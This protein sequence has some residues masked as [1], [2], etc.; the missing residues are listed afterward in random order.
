[1]GVD[2]RRAPAFAARAA[3]D[4]FTAERR[5]LIMEAGRLQRLL[6]VTA[7]PALLSHTPSPISV[8]RTALPASTSTFTTAAAV[9]A[10]S[11]A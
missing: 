1:M 5:S 11:R 6:E 8:G 7:T 4:Y 10:A 3:L 2:P 9:R